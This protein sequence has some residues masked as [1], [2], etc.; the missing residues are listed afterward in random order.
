MRCAGG[1]G[2]WGDSNQE[3]LCSICYKKKYLGAPATAAM[4]GINPAEPKKCIK[5]CGLYGSDKFSGMCSQCHSKEK[6]KAAV[7][8][9]SKHRWQSVRRQLHAVY[10]F[11]LGK[12]EE[13]ANKG[14]CFVC[15]K[16]L[17][18]P[19]ECR[20][21]RTFCSA[22][23]FP[24]DHQ[25]SYDAQ[26]FHPDVRVWLHDGSVKEV[27]Y[28]LPTD[29]LLDEAGQPISIVQD[30]LIGT[31][32]F[33]Q[34]PPG[35]PLHAA[36]SMVPTP[37][38]APGSLGTF[39][40]GYLP[41]RRISGVLG[42]YDDFTVTDRHLLTVATRQCATPGHQMNISI[43]RAQSYHFPADCDWPASLVQYGLPPALVGQ[44]V[45]GYTAPNRDR[46]GCCNIRP[47][48]WDGGLDPLTNVPYPWGGNPV[49]HYRDPRAG[50]LPPGG[51]RTWQQA[52]Q[53]Q[54]DDWNYIHNLPTTI[55]LGEY[56]VSTIEAMP[57][58]MRG[59]VSRAG[60]WL[61]K[62]HI[63]K[64]SAP[65]VFNPANNYVVGKLD[66]AMGDCQLPT[67]LVDNVLYTSHTYY[68]A[69][70][71][72][73]ALRINAAGAFV[74]NAA[75]D[76]A[77][78]ASV[79]EARY[80][81]RRNPHQTVYPPTAAALDALGV[82]VGRALAP[83]P[84]A[85]GPVVPAPLV[86]AAVRDARIAALVEYIVEVTAWI[87]GVWLTDGG[88]DGLCITQSLQTEWG[89][90]NHVVNDHAGVFE[91][92]RHW[93][94]LLGVQHGTFRICGAGLGGGVHA[95]PKSTL[96]F[97]QVVPHLQPIGIGSVLRN[98]L[99]RCGV[100]VL[101][102]LVPGWSTAE[103]DRATQQ[104]ELLNKP[105][106]WD[107]ALRNMLGWQNETPR[108]RRALLAGLIDGDGSR[109]RGP[110]GRADE[111]ETYQFIQGSVYKELV[112]WV[113][114]LFRQ[115]GWS[116]CRPAPRENG[117]QVRA[118]V[119][120]PPLRRPAAAADRYQAQECNAHWAALPVSTLLRLPC[121]L[122]RRSGSATAVGCT[123]RE[124][125]SDGWDR[126]RPP[127]SR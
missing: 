59:Q 90:D 32:G 4:T 44:P 79:D 75:G 105:R 82:A 33:P 26:C 10:L 35:H 25:C 42:G 72:E 27:K 12:Q 97:H 74:N 24:L 88:S 63:A 121:P 29:R 126:D 124:L 71:L 83:P 52:Q 68:R 17:P 123:G 43:R 47:Y 73:F 107:P 53:A 100:V 31:V 18:V 39:N 106:F 54:V 86:V 87:A 119:H 92:C 118:G 104:A 49:G 110:G 127:S 36:R 117:H 8:R 45:P 7:K 91:R 57:P 111:T 15:T 22:H 62:L 103:R 66:M 84:P 30:T 5:N 50:P 95:L 65:I 28:L 101:P 77:A 61:G 85:F 76:V 67:G 3:N 41:L 120:Q 6:E 115:L 40:P 55:R 51:W 21:R 78:R 99:M 116:T 48:Y 9:T 1:C 80:R 20:C 70:Q 108:T 89:L 56:P 23:R 114:T 13:Q 38:A 113:C 2:Y 14:R 60:G 16:R 19:I 102:V 46:G 34:P 93:V 81:D 125:R 109:I 122:H 94:D 69:A 58:S 98:F 11:T 112:E 37:S 96:Y 64:L